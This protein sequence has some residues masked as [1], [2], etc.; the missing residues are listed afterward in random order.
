MKNPEYITKICEGCEN[1]KFKIYL[2]NGEAYYCCITKEKS[3]GINNKHY[4]GIIKNMKEMDK[5]IS[6]KC[7]ICGRKIF[8][9]VIDNKTKEVHSVECITCKRISKRVIEKN[10]KIYDDYDSEKSLENRF[11][12]S[13]GC[14]YYEREKKWELEKEIEE[15]MGELSEIKRK[16][17]EINQKYKKMKNYELEIINR[18]KFDLF[19]KRKKEL[20]HI[21][22]QK[23][24]LY[25]EL[26]I[27][28]AERNC[29]EK[30]VENLKLRKEK[31]KKNEF[32]LIKEKYKE[33]NK[34]TEI[35]KELKKENKI[36]KSIEWELSK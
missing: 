15:R 20:E 17:N 35:E 32:E 11:S 19:K 5:K 31:D 34:K 9:V 2:K 10:N 8:K 18:K 26:K 6:S 13:K 24:E 36:E 21:K 16:E 29:L 27:I 3:S 22:K 4:T 7:P 1:N 33:L 14:N 30:S 23:E 28:I 12:K 25:L